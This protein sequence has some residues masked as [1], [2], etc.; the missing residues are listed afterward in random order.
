VVFHAQ[1][2]RELRAFDFDDVV[3]SICAKM[4]RRHP[5]VFADVKIAD[6]AAQSVAWESLKAEER[7][8]SADEGASVLADVGR[9]LP[10]L[11]RA[12]KI[13]KRAAGVG[14]DWTGVDG[15]LARIEEELGELAVARAST[16]PRAVMDE[17][18]DVL[19]SVVNLSRHLRVDPEEALRRAT[20]KFETRFR[21][22]EEAV[23][24]SGRGWSDW[25]PAELE[26]AWQR[27]KETAAD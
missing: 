17:I 8:K 19:F 9:A 2:A 15:V 20:R 11:T 23:R 6:A 12:E 18:G 3:A 27:A 4:V 16:D 24:A 26:A 7:R 22:V 1:I 10:A 5:H 14:F 25:Q 13:G 21:R